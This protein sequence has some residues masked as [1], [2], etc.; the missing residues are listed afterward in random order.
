M[1]EAVSEPILRVNRLH[2]HFFTDKGV[3]PA[4]DGVDFTLYKGE[5]VGLVGES[6]CGKSVTSLSILKLIPQPPGK[7][8]ADKM[9]FKSEDL[10]HATERRMRQLRGNDIS[11]IFQDPMSS[12]NPTFTIGHQLSE[13]IRIH[14]KASRKEALRQSVE[15]LSKVGIPRAERTVKDYP[16]QLSGG[17]RQRVM[18]AMATACQPELLIADEPTTALDVTIQAQILNLMKQLNQD[19]GTAILLITHDLG[20]VAEV[21]ERVLVM[22]AGKVVEEGDV[23]SILKDPQHPYT[24]GLIASVPKRNERSKRLYSIPGTVPKPGSLKRGCAFAPRCTFAFDSCWMEEPELYPLGYGRRS[25]CLLHREEG[26]QR[27]E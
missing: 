1:A 24:Q 20:V 27:I 4:V 5:V 3:I 14:K 11:M 26:S 10:I 8:S 9:E 18:I 12:L 23:R 13:V 15:M 21:C 16:H 6:G 19:Q 17:M 22:Y 7:I 2:T 25:R